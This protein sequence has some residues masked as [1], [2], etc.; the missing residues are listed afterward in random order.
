MTLRI[1]N[2]AKLYWYFL[3]KGMDLINRFKATQCNLVFV[4]GIWDWCWW[5][6]W[7]PKIIVKSWNNDESDEEG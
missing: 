6:A 2:Q 7:G 1:L 3:A 4:F 5:E